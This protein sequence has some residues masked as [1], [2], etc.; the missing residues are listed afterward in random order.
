[1]ISSIGGSKCQSNRS[2]KWDADVG[3]LA[4]ERGRDWGHRPSRAGLVES[5]IDIQM[6]SK[7]SIIG[8]ARLGVVGFDRRGGGG[9]ADEQWTAE[10]KWREQ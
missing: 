10:Q 9:S 1:M 7:I 8:L 5:P 2:L 4:R 3:V 6:D